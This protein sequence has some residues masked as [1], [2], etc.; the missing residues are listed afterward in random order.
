MTANWTEQSKRFVLGHGVVLTAE[1]R[2]EF[3]TDQ[4]K[5]VAEMIEKA[6]GESKEGTFVLS[7][8]M[9]ELNYALQSKEHPRRTRGYGNKP[10]K[11]ALKSTTDSNTKKR[12]HD[13]LFENKIQEKVHIILQA[14]REKMHE[15]FQGHIQEQVQA[16]L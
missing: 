1:G 13:E 12:K 9:D 7:R 15:S 14:E 5:Q 10:W 2:F 6:H 4:V 16:Q 8:D 11:H 3:K